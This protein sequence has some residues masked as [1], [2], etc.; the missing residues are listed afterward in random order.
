ML[1]A[2]AATLRT[3]S[4]LGS[5]WSSGIIR[6]SPAPSGAADPAVSVFFVVAGFGRVAVLA[7]VSVLVTPDPEETLSI[8]SSPATGLPFLLLLPAATLGVRGSAPNETN[9]S[10][11]MDHLRGALHEYAFQPFKRFYA[12]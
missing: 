3:L 1:T 2:L 6:M 4:G 11:L 12:F 10:Q 5:S 9:L 8:L 7:M